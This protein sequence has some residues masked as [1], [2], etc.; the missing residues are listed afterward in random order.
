MNNK[1]KELI[2]SLVKVILIKISE[3]KNYH[4]AYKNGGVKDG[5]N[6]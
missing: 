5:I 4:N 2:E 1:L 3:I 6:L